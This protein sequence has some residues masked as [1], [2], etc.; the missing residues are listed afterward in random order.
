MKKSE[1]A[2]QYE[3]K[4][5]TMFIAASIALVA[6]SVL[7]NIV[8]AFELSSV[9]KYIV[10]FFVVAFIIFAYVMTIKGFSIVSKATKL[11][12]ENENYYMGRN[13][14]IMTVASLVLS[15]I[16]ELF[17]LICYLLL[18][19]YS[20]AQNLSAD[21]IT[22]ANNLRIITAVILVFAQLVAISTA[23]IFYLWKIH[24]FTP[25]NDSI[26]NFAL[27]TMIV[28]CVQLVIGIMNPLYTVKGSSSAFISSF[29]GILLSLKYIIL[30]LFFITRRKGLMPNADKDKNGEADEGGEQQKNYD[31]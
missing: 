12:E 16:A 20:V 22:A 7:T 17:I 28:L 21:D 30:L 18:Y 15:V 29:S 27:L 1:I 23:Y 24:K 8:N 5:T 25:K 4:A 10:Q 14:K 6:N 19:N 31:H 11:S 3:F 2:K 26:N 9:F 13:L